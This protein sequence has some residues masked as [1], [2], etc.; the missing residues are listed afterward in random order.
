MPR[1]NYKKNYKINQ[2]TRKTY[3]MPSKTK[4]RYSSKAQAWQQAQDLMSLNHNIK[5][6]VY[7][8]IDLGWYLT[9]DK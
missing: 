8:D 1:R 3:S 4:K 9:Q 2:P 7:Q 6:K 5:L